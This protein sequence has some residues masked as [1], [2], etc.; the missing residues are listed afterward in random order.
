MTCST[1]RRGN[2][3]DFT[4]TPQKLKTLSV[5]LAVRYFDPNGFFA[6]VGVTYVDQEVVRTDLMPS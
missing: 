3:T 4:S 5:P 2:L 6:G 1:Q